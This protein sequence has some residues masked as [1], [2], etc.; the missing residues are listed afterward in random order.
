VEVLVAVVK[1]K[2]TAT[3][4]RLTVAKDVLAIA[5]VAASPN[6]P[7]D[8]KDKLDGLLKKLQQ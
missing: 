2:E 7:A 3:E 1:G 6:T 4:E 5:Q 8:V